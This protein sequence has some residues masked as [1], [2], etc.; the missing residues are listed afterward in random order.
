MSNN[1]LE[2]YVDEIYNQADILL[3]SVE[4]EKFK[5]ELESALIEKIGTESIDMLDDDSK[6]EYYDFL[7]T[8]P[9]DDEIR[10]FFVSHIDNFDE[11]INSVI[12][13]FCSEIITKI[14]TSIILASTDVDKYS[15]KLDDENKSIEEILI[16]KNK[17][18]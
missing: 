9:A 6:D 7:E 2:Q 18:N 16:D 15:N 10:S 5:E 17:N 4:E 12:I 1:I 8:K 11:K 14:K 13:N 3:T